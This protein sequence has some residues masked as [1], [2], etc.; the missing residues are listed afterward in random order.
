MNYFQVLSSNLR[1]RYEANCGNIFVRIVSLWKGRKNEIS[2]ERNYTHPESEISDGRCSVWDSLESKNVTSLPCGDMLAPE[3]TLFHEHL[4]CGILHFIV[5]VHED[6]EPH[7]DQQ[8]HRSAAA[9]TQFVPPHRA[10]SLRLSLHPTAWLIWG[11]T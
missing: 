5:R 3:C 4:Q 9:R 10:P 11:V 6:Y 2:D 8:E 1:I 7:A